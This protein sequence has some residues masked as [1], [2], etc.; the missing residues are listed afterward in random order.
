VVRNPG[1]RKRGFT[2]A[3]LLVVAGLFSLIMALTSLIFFSGRDA[4]V[5]S[6]EKVETSGRSRRALDTLT[7]LVASTVE[8]GGFDA[9]S[10]FD[11]VLDD[12]TDACHMDLTTRENYMHRAYSPTDPF[13]ADGPY[14]RYRVQ[15]EPDSQELKLY[16]LVITP[17]GVDTAVP[18]RLLA[19]NVRGCRLQVF[20]VGTVAVTIQIQADKE[21]ERRPDGV[22]TTTL[23]AILSSPGNK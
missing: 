21:N 9:I 1:I 4:M 15:Y 13:D 6:T 23:T 12:M 14:Y 16:Q 7:P 2:I 3:E 8:T 5:Q 11:L 19:H 17:V 18:P 10:V 20:T 22:T